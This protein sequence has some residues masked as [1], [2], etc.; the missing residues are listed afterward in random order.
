MNPYENPPTVVHLELLSKIKIGG[1][2]SWI[3]K[4]KC[5]FCG[6]I[7]KHGAGEANSIR[8][9][10]LGLRIAHCMNGSYIITI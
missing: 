9:I 1:K 7:H 8:S 3:V 6:K 4:V 10:N 2:E 5:P